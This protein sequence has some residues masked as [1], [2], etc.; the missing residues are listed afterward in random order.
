LKRGGKLL[1]RGKG[2][3]AGGREGLFP[4]ACGMGNSLGGKKKVAGRKRGN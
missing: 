1:R 3:H 4:D 2:S